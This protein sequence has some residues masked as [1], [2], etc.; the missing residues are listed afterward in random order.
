MV[1]HLSGLRVGDKSKDVSLLRIDIAMFALIPF[2]SIDDFRKNQ[3]RF[4]RLQHLRF[5]ERIVNRIGPR[6]KDVR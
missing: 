5:V 4:N 2:G 6:A 3:L 1:L